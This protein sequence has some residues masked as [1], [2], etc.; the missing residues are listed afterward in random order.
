MYDPKGNG[1]EKAVEAVQFIE[2]EPPRHLQG[3]VHRFL[4]LKTSGVLAEDYRFHALPDACS[5]I[6]FDQQNLTITGVSKLRA[7]SQE[8]NLG[9]SFHFV[10]IRFL[11]GVWQ[12]SKEPLSYGMVE[13]EYDGDLPLRAINRDLSKRPFSEQQPI[14]IDLVETLIER[15]MVAPNPVTEKIFEHLDDI[16]SVADMAEV[17]GISARQLQRTLKR[18]TDFTPH[19]FLKVL[20]LQQA[21]N[22]NDTWSY[23]DQ[24]HFIHSFR[25]ATGYTPGK[26]SKKFD[27]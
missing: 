18:T 26:Y 9:R 23:A 4:E 5:Y 6:V 20:R 16:T 27:V 15:K 7:E 25:K 17:S 8:F 14:L 3:I 2:A 13:Q 19:D 12:S 24:S 22:G 11:P 21:L 1:K 10:N